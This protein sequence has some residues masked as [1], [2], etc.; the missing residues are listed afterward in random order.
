MTTKTKTYRVTF[1][2]YKSFSKTFATFEEAYDYMMEKVRWFKNS[3]WFIECHKT[4]N[5]FEG[6]F[7]DWY[8]YN[9]RVNIRPL[10]K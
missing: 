9:L 8:R 7:A 1:E 6:R 5:T 10:Y 2:D 4:A 3:Y